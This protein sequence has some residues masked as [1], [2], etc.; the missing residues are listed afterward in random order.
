MQARLAIDQG[1]TATKAFIADPGG[2]MRELGRHKHRQFYPHPGWVEHDAMELLQA[3]ERFCRLADADA[4]IGIANQGE[5]VVAWDARTK[6]PFYNAIIWQDQRTRDT[7]ERLRAEGLEQLTR[8]RAGLPLDP[9]FSAA[10][11]RWLL[12]NVAG[13]RQAA[14]AGYLRLGTSDSFF[15]DNLTGCFATD[16]S[17]ASRTSL[18]NLRT[19]SWDPDLCEAFGVPIECLPDIRSTVDDFG[20]VSSGDARICVNIV[21]QQAALFGHGCRKPGDI[22][23]TFGTGAFALG[24]SEG[25]SSAM[26][27]ERLGLAPTCAWRIRDEKAQYA[28]DGG[29]LSAASAIDWL[30]RIG[31]ADAVDAAENDPPVALRGL[32]FVPAQA[33]LGCPFWDSSARALWIG[34]ELATS[35]RDLCRAVHEGIALRTAQIVRTFE[36]LAGV[37]RISVDGGVSKSTYF[38]QLLADATGRSLLIS[39]IAD[40]TAKG[41]LDLC[42]LARPDGDGAGEIEWQRIEPR[43]PMPETVHARFADAVDRA[44]DWAR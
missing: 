9:Y 4:V 13:V 32:M 22:K 6:R 7:I 39:D 41:V 18:M 31:L 20:C 29:L 38:R 44:R 36:R 19:L 17:T 33:G 5:T 14:A 23:I 30:E 34:M 40:M 21:D 15:L 11:L 8:E 35:R 16:V 1:T 24:L 37:S 26:D 43:A 28:V 27:A 3:V 42:G 12:D 25:V 10:K 2:G